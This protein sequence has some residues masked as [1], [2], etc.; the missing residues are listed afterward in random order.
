MAT[1]S[2]RVLFDF[3]F[4]PLT[5]TEYQQGTLFAVFLLTLLAAGVR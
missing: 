2:V 4:D 3:Q 1:L 5:Y